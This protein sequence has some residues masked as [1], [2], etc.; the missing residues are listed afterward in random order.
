MLVDYRRFPV[1]ALEFIKQNR[2]T[3]NLATAFDWGS[4]ALWKLYPQCKILVDGRYEEVYPDHAF[5]AAMRFSQKGERWWEVLREF[6]TDVVVLPKQIYRQAD[7]AFLPEW[8]FV[9]QDEVSVVL[10]PR[11]RLAGPFVSP[12][13]K[14]AAYAREDWTKPV[15][16]GS[17]SQ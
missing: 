6:P 10:L 12:D 9:Y 4:Y 1:G 5:A 16:L 14:D 15:A 13:F 3:G 7:L 8:K 2:L 17:G 11:N